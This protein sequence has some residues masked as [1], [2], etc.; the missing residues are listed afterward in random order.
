MSEIV[1]TF[2]SEPYFPIK[3]SVLCVSTHMTYWNM[4]PFG[5]DN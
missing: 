2:D 3:F 4:R 5:S 1:R